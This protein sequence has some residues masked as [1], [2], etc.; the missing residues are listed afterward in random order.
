MQRGFTLLETLAALAVTGLVLAALSSG[1]RHGLRVQAAQ[2]RTRDAKAELDTVDRLLRRLIAQSDPQAPL[3][4]SAG[5]LDF[6]SE[7]P[8]GS[9][10]ATGI[11]EIGL[12]VDGQ[13]RL[14]L[15]WAPRLAGTSIL[16]PAATR[17]AV[18]LDNVRSV[19][20]SYWDVSKSQWDAAWA[21]TRPPGL[22]RIAV[23]FRDGDARH[24]PD[25]VVAPMRQAAQDRAPVPPGGLA[26][27]P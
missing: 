12:G 14:V 6:V 13:H 21:G 24:W 26:R 10:I 25:I 15:R 1:L 17:Q 11:A 22:I 27:A 19:R 20:L 23:T 3:H 16:E 5:T 7:L 18:L 9:G 8:D 2:D 4:G